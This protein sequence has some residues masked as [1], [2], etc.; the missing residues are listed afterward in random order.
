MA[1]E[2][3]VGSQPLIEVRD[4]VRTYGEGEATVHAL[5]GIDLSIN[6]REMVALMGPSGSGKSTLMNILGLFDR[7]SRGSY[8]LD[9]QDMTRLSRRQQASYRGRHIAFVFQ[10]IHL[11]PRLSALANVELPMSYARMPASERR[12]QAMQALEL[13][14]I[15]HLKDRYPGQMSGGQAQ[16]VAIARAIA[17]NPLLLL[18]DEPTGALDRKSGALVLQAF[19]EL[20]ANTGVTIVV[21]TH[22]P[23]VS[24]H[25]ERIVSLEDGQIIDDCPVEDRLIASHS[26]GG[27]S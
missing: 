6:A 22:D 19:Q 16:R 2:Q 5:R 23:T 12:K 8:S 25:A 11:L 1:V 26:E 9:G 20:H 17:P 3:N 14:G 15:A 4:L 27:Q 21:V 24:Q 7:P 18:A 10:G 13:L